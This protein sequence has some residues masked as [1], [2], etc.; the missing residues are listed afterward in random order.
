MLCCCFLISSVES[1]SAQA[2]IFKI[3]TEVFPMGRAYVIRAAGFAGAAAAGGTIGNFTTDYVKNALKPGDS[4]HNDITLNSLT[5]PTILCPE[6]SCAFNRKMPDTRMTD[7]PKTLSTT[8]P[9]AKIPAEIE[10]ERWNTPEPSGSFAAKILQTRPREVIDFGKLDL[11]L[12]ELPQ[13][14]TILGKVEAGPATEQ[15]P[16]PPPPPGCEQEGLDGMTAMKR[17][18]VLDDDTG[19]SKRNEPAARQ[20]Y[21]AAALKNIPI[22][23]YS[24]ADMLLSGDGGPTDAIRGIQYLEAAALNGLPLAQYRLAQFYETATPADMRRALQW[25]GEAAVAGSPEAQYELSRFYY[26]GLGTLTPDRIAAFG[27]LNVALRNGYPPATETMHTLLDNLDADARA[28]RPDALFAMG[29]AWEYGVPGFIIADPRRAL[30]IYL[31]AQRQGWPEADG[32]LRHL[33]ASTNVCR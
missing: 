8:T 32:A 20:C 27:W 17:A 25:Y 7:P 11:G 3:V 26:Q 5:R 9:P 29:I 4:A 22:A 24:L 33:C 19:F 14:K 31:N 28:Y 12:N 30:N 16:P 2:V 1:G 10:S 15:V 21:L 23:Q 6:L 18:V 13:D